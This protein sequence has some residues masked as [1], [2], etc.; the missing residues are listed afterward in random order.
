[1]KQIPLRRD[2]TLEEAVGRFPETMSVFRLL[3]ICCISDRNRD[4]T[5]EEL[6]LS[7]GI[8]PGPFL[9]ALHKKI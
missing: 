8:E 4:M 3:G 6:C 9:E 1:M 7:R 5:I 2:T